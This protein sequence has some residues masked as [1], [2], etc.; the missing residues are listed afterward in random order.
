MAFCG[1]CLIKQLLRTYAVGFGFRSFF[2]PNYTA[3]LSPDSASYSAQP[4]ACAQRLNCGFYEYTASCSIPFTVDCVKKFK[5][6]QGK[7]FVLF[8]FN[9]L[10]CSSAKKI[11][12]HVR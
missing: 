2:L 5:M 10:Y 8:C 9:Y 6:T 1:L 11:N 3:D 4:P 12:I 7:C